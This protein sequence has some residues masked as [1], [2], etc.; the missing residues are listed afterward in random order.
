MCE[1]AHIGVN[2]FKHGQSW[3]Q[4]MLSLQKREEEFLV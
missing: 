1:A 4:V 3:T 2:V